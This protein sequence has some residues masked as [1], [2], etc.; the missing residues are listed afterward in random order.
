M[1]FALRIAEDEQPHA[2]KRKVFDE[3]TVTIGRAPQN[4]L[5]LRDK[6][7]MVSNHHGKI[8]QVDGSFYLV[9][10]NSTNSTVLNGTRL[11]PHQR[12]PLRDGDRFRI[13]SFS[14]QFRRQDSPA[15]DSAFSKSTSTW[16]ATSP[17]ARETDAA[18]LRRAVE[19]LSFLNELA[20]EIGGT[21]EMAAIIEKV[22]RRSVEAAEAEQGTVTLIQ[23][24]E[25]DDGAPE[26]KTFVRSGGDMPYH[27]DRSLLQ[28]MQAHKKALLIN[29]V[30]QDPVFRALSFSSSIRSILCVPLLIRSQLTGSITLFNSR[31]AG[32]FTEDDE[33]RLAIIAAQSAQIIENARLYEEEKQFVQMQ[34]ELQ[35][36]RS[37]QTQLLPAE[38]PTIAGYD[39]AGKSVPAELVGGDYFDHIQI[40]DHRWGLAVGD[41][42]GKGLP[43]SLVMANLQATLRSQALWCSDA[44]ECV[45]RANHLLCRSTNRHTFV[46][47]WYGV[48][49]TRSH[50]LVYANGGHNR[51]YRL[52]A[53]G[54]IE[55]LREGG[56]VLGFMPDQVYAEQTVP[57]NPGDT[58]VIY[59][60]GITEAMNRHHE[61]FLEER[62]ERLLPTLAGIPARTLIDRLME[63]VGDHA[64]GT[65]PSDDM[66]ILVARRLPP[67]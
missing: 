34:Q 46:T 52:A 32:G 57:L 19:E 29:N 42:S 58:L 33:R 15:A 3:E 17:L 48:L 21:T 50:T 9:D 59:S 20:L 66:T 35:T 25:P 40:D 63:A 11:D 23:D 60:D 30:H 64:A 22:V 55:C 2:P 24:I 56:L 4:S 27:L 13:G 5:V 65:A 26:A 47:L 7:R 14:L 16:G 51:P 18:T 28:W 39:V 37:I 12:Y 43:A 31:K 54:T 45:A 1:S 10:L 8:Q 6:R 41:V 49:D 67:G 44:A 62:L 36:A 53:D 38:A 61:E